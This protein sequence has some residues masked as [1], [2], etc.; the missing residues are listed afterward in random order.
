MREAVSLRLNGVVGV[1]F[2]GFLTYSERLNAVSYL[3]LLQRGQ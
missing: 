3:R 2:C 1:H